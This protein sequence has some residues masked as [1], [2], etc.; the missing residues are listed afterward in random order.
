[1]YNGGSISAIVK[2]NFSFYLNYKDEWE[3]DV[4]EVLDVKLLN[5]NEKDTMIYYIQEAIFNGSD[6]SQEEV[7]GLDFN[8]VMETKGIDF[9]GTF[10]F[11]EKYWE[12][13]TQDGT[14]TDCET[15]LKCINWKIVKE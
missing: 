14:E 3:L 15:T 4:N 13:S 1:M 10:R 8:E 6:Y 7:E 9:E 2:L 11:E 5:E 12:Y